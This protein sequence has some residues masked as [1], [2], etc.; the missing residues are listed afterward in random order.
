MSDDGIVTAPLGTRWVRKMVIIIAVLIAFGAWGLYDAVSVYPARGER[1]ARWAELQYLDAAQRAN[2]EDFGIFERDTSVPN[3]V[4][5]YERLND[6]ERRRTNAADMG[7]TGSPR[8]LRA[9][10][11]SARLAWLEGLKRI[12]QLKPERTTIENP[13]AR[14]EALR[15]EVSATANP[16]PLAGYDIPSQWAIMAVCWGIALVMVVHFVRVASRKYRWDPGL[17]ALTIPGG[18]TITPGDLAEVDKRKWDKFIVFLKIKE[19]R[20]PLGGREV[21]VDLYQHGLVEG[22]VLEMEREAFGPQE[23]GED[24]A[25]TG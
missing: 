17:K 18:A 8:Q 25:A 16:K 13:R 5:E 1:Y 22:W 21:R 9:A 15:Q 20:Q 11:Q 3:P 12:G 6:P 2:G 7:N 19:G 4:E 10:M 24:E 14:L 23:G